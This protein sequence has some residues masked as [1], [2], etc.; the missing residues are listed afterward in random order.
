VHRLDLALWLMGYPE[1]VAVSGSTYNVIAKEMARK[2]KQRYTVEDLS[3]GIIKFANGATLI[4]E[5]SWA[6]NIGDPEERITSLYGTRGGLVERTDV[7]GG[8]G[9]VAEIYTEEGGNLYTKR[10]DRALTPAPSAYREFIDSI[11]EQRQPIATGEQGAKVMRILDAL[12][13]S[14]ETGKEVRCKSAT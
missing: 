2:A 1:P 8:Y 4:L 7:R 13:K 10:L 14:A 6:L 12:Y 5:A 9:E 3:A 11:V